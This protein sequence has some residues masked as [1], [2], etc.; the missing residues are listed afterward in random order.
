MEIYILIAA[1][2]A[3]GIFSFLFGFVVS[4]LFK[5]DVKISRKE[6]YEHK[7]KQFESLIADLEQKLTEA[8]TDVPQERG[9]KYHPLDMFPANL[10]RDY[11]LPRSLDEE[12]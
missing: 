7:I 11:G 1:A 4:G 6:E 5:V 10:P 12:V 3:I 2:S 9:P 8:E